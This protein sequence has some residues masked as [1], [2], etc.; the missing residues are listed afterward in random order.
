[1]YQDL[2]PRLKPAA[3]ISVLAHMIGMVGRGEAACEGEPGVE[4]VYALA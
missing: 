1:M 3:A 2:D 4:S